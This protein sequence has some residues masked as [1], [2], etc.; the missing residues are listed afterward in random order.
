M[1]MDNL[2]A[3]EFNESEFGMEGWWKTIFLG[4]GGEEKI[5]MIPYLTP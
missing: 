5:E 1:N 3:A 2:T 4:G